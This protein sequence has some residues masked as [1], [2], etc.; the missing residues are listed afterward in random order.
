MAKSQIRQYVFTPGGV[1]LGTIEVPG[2]YDLSQFLVIT[3]TTR[4]SIIYNFADPT[5]SGTTVQFQRI[6]DNNFPTSLDN[7]DGVTIIT[8]QTDTSAMLAGDQLQILYE[9]PFQYVRSPEIGTD[10]FERQRVASPQSLLDADFEYGMQPTKWLTLSAQRGYPTAYE[11]PGTDLQVVAATSDASTNEGGTTTSESIITITT[12]VAHGYSAGQPVSIFGFNSAFTGYD[13]A[14]GSF[15]I[16]TIPSTT[17]FTYYAKGKVGFNNGDNIWTASVQL[18]QAGVYTGSNI[19]AVINAIATATTAAGY[20][21]TLNA[22]AGMTVGSTILFNTVNTNA[23]ATDSTSGYITLGTTIGLAV[24]MPLYFS[25]SSLGGIQAGT[26]YYVRNIIDIRTVT[27]SLSSGGTL[28]TPSSTSIGG[29]MYVVAGAQFGNISLSTP[30]YVT[31]IN[32]N[33]ITISANLNYNTTITST[34][35]LTN[36]VRFGTTVNMTVGEQVTI[37]GTTIGNLIAGTYYVYQ[38]LDNNY[39][40]LSSSSPTDSTGMITFIQTSASGSMVANVGAV[41][42]VSQA[43]G[44]LSAQVICPPSFSYANPATTATCSGSFSGNQMTVTSMSSGTITNGNGVSGVGVASNPNV[45]YQLTPTGASVIASPTLASGGTAGSYTFVVN[46]AS[47]I[48]IGMII[49]GTGIQVNTLVTGINSSTITLSRTF[50]SGGSGV[51]NFYQAGGVGTYLMSSTQTLSS[52]SLS[53]CSG[54]AVVTVNFTSPHGLLPGATI[55]VLV[56]SEDGF[57]NH[58][59]VSGPYFVDSVPNSNTI[60]YT[61]R[62]INQISGTI[63]ASV[64]P[65]ADTFFAHR[66]FDGGVQLGTGLP[67]HG[68]QAIRMSKKYIRYQS[69]KSINFNTGLLMAPNYFVRS[70]TASSN[71]V[72]TG[73]T[74]TQINTS[75]VATITSNLNYVQ[76]MAVVVTSVTLSG[77]IGFTTGTYFISAVNSST[78]ITLASTYSSALSGGSITTVTF[79]GACSASCTVNPTIRIVTDDVDHGCQ[80]GASVNLLGVSTSGYNGNYV[81]VDI[82][83]ERS[84]RVVANQN[85]GAT[86]GYTGASVQDPCL[87]SLANWYGATVRSGTFDEQNGVFW[88]Y[89]GQV[90]SVVRRSSTFQLAGT[91]SL[92]V[93]S[94][95]VIGSNT[96][97]TTQLFTGDRVVIRGMTHV[98]TQVSGDT[99]CYVNPQW[100]GTASVQSIKFTK[101][102]DYVVPQSKWNVDRCDGSNGAYNNSGYKINPIKMQMVAT[103][104]TWYGAGFIDWMLRGPDGKYITVHRLRNNNL[105]NEAWMRAGNMPVRY[106]VSNDGARSFISGDQT[107]SS[108]DTVMP[109]YDSSSFPLPAPGNSCIVYVDNEFI[110]YKT[111][112]NINATATSATGNT[113]TVSSTTGLALNQ[114]IAF[115]SYGASVDLG[116]VLNNKT[117]YVKSIV[118]S[119]SITLSASAGGTVITQVNATL[120]QGATFVAGALTGCTRAQSITPFATGSYRT[121]TAGSAATHTP[122]TGVVLVNQSATPIISHWGAAFIEDGGFDS[123]R[124]Y[125]FNYQATNVNISTKKTTAFAIRLAP[126]VSNALPGDLGQRELI[127]R[128]SFLLQQLESSSGAGGTNAAIVVEAILNPSNFPALTNIKFDSLSSPVNPTG[129][130]SFSQV[131]PGVGMVFTNSINTF[132][133]CP[134]YVQGNTTSIPLTSAPASSGVAISDDVYFPTSTSSLYGLTK[135]ALITSSSASITANTTNSNVSNFTANFEGNT[136]TVTAVAGGTIAVGMLLVGSSLGS[137]T[138]ITNNITGTGTGVG[139][140]TVSVTQT[141]GNVSVV[142]TLAV[143]TVNTVPSGRVTV[144]SLVAGGTIQ[145][146]TYIIAAGTGTGGIGTYFLNVSQTGTT[147]S[148][149]IFYG[150]TLNQPVLAP[151]TLFGGTGTTVNISRSTYALPGETVFSYINSPANK[152]ALDLSPLKELTNTPIGGRGCY[153]NGSD[154]MFIN[155]YITQGAPINTNL[156]LRWGEAQA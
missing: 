77:A 58:T 119:T 90:V 149:L 110:S 108:G 7:F 29:N 109:V 142:G 28:F 65:R 74:I 66:P 79:S 78:S 143:L 151:V 130:P 146:N 139:K 57:N 42:Q 89:D 152:D 32:S 131:A 16:S 56:S 129:Q 106:E 22:T 148:T 10:A 100:R 127:N 17:T 30:Y 3:N 135:V 125:I 41:L 121:F 83:D 155:V 72:L 156:V 96:R 82:V 4:N 128:A 5:Y 55:N 33:Q 118:N 36:G 114:P 103:Q 51:Y 54:Q 88:Q 95:Q 59:V 35:S 116:N 87:L 113:V 11:I 141:I 43:T 6:S 117:Y 40:I 105:N 69:G 91:I 150:I 2:K 73:L 133:I 1:G 123:D 138:Y 49:T 75:G 45:I 154:I 80:I 15:F 47:N 34:N 81:V 136:M 115:V 132:L 46:T 26:T 102:I 101:V 20:F 120:S 126:S 97:F 60:V 68:T 9:Q 12:S 21:I 70:V 50:T 111:K 19:N 18:R 145:P 134:I 63:I 98:I 13:R 31:S 67:A 53:F 39:A 27:V 24:N 23:I 94:G 124:S 147:A 153:P 144:G 61:A 85:L 71:T 86:V 14:E 140:W 38:L 112:I 37:T 52:S 104:W 107:M 93:G 64:F 25:G 44:F 122:A 84:V 137:G 76:G 92:V 62:A 48:S 99:L 8:L